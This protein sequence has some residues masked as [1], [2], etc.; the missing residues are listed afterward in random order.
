[1]LL[2]HHGAY[3]VWKV[4]I[5]VYKVHSYVWLFIVFLP[6]QSTQH[7]RYY[8][9]LSTGKNLLAQFLFSLSYFMTQMF[10]VPPSETSLFLVVGPV[11]YALNAMEK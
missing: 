9:N 8:E 1:M 2:L 11:G 4:N 7:L 6:Q 3:L 10:D 5:V